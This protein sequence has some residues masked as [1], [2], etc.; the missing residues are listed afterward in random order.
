[1][2]DIDTH[3]DTV[4]GAKCITVCDVPSKYRQIPVA[5]NEIVKAA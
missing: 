2:P 5:E 3:K 4:G 1:M